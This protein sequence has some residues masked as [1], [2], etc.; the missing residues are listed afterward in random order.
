MSANTHGG[1]GHWK[2]QRLSSLL[3][4]P[5]TAWLLWAIISVAGAEY[6]AAAE[7]FRTPFHSAMALLTAAVMVH[8][9]QSGVTVVCEDYVSPPGLQTALIWLTRLGCLVG[10][11]A[12]AYTLYTLRQGA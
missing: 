9:A 6:A 12:T 11:L 4:I 7:F 8:H 3:L 2:S 10:F 5:L 1:L